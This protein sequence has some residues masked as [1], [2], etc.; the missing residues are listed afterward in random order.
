MAPRQALVLMYRFAAA[1]RRQRIDGILVVDGREHLSL[2]HVGDG[3]TK[4]RK[5]L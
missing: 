5:K 1:I 2:L 4:S 3:R